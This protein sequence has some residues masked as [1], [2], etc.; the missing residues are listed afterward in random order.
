MIG[1]LGEVIDYCRT[2][3]AGWRFL[4]SSSYRQKIIKEWKKEEWYSVAWD[5]VCGSAGVASSLLIVWLVI[6]LI[7]FT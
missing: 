3:W 1:E 7:W 4:L 2:G 6:Y 5:M